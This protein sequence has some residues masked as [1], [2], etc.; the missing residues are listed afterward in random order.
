MLKKNIS[1][2]Q[3]LTAMYQPNRY[4]PS[5]KNNE[6][7]LRQPVTNADTLVV[8]IKDRILDGTFR[9][10]AFIGS[11]RD[12][13][14]E[15]CVSRN[16]AREALRSLVALGAV[17]ISLGVKGGATVALGDAEA[18]G[19]TLAIQYRLSGV[20]EDE[21]LEVQSVLEGLA[22]ERAAEHATSQDIKI[23]ENLIGE[24]ELLVNNSAEFSNSSLAFHAAI[25]EA[26]HSQALGMQLRSIRYFIWPPNNTIPNQGL[27]ENIL[28]SHRTLL[29]LIKNGDA[30][31]ASEFMRDHIEHI[32]NHHRKIR[33]G[34]SVAEEACC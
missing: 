21:V 26:S 15:Y 3:T 30:A 10:G 6:V 13:S 24:A 34:V 18:I 17:E 7:R 1:K 23:L 14:E 16:T 11:E 27:A 4:V 19:E 31:G 25:V 8:Q 5:I 20:P 9:P 12:I 2:D 32:R 29:D 33:E 28:R 22:A